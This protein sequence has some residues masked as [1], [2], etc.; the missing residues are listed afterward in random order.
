MF[1]QPAAGARARSETSFCFICFFGEGI[2][3]AR[4]EPAWHR[5][6]RRLRSEDRTLLRISAAA[7]RLH[8]HHGS[9][10]PRLTSQGAMPDKDLQHEKFDYVRQLEAKLKEI[11]ATN[12]KR[13]GNSANSRRGEDVRNGVYDWICEQCGEVNFSWRHFC[14][15]NRCMGRRPVEH[16]PGSVQAGDKSKGHGLGKGR[17]KTAKGS[18][19]KEGG[20]E[21]SRGKGRGQSEWI[22]VGKGMRK[23]GDKAD[24]GKDSRQPETNPR[25]STTIQ[26]RFSA[27]EDSSI[28]NDPMGS[29][30]EGKEDEKDEE[31]EEGAAETNETEARA[32]GNSKEATTN[33]TQVQNC[34]VDELWYKWKEE[35]GN[36]KSVKAALGGNRRHPAAEAAKSAMDRAR[37]AYLEARPEPKDRVKARILSNKTKRLQSRKD[38]LDKEIED[39]VTKT[40]VLEGKRDDVMRNLAATERDIAQL[41]EKMGKDNNQMQGR[42]IPE[43]VATETLQSIEAVIPILAKATQEIPQESPN[44]VAVQMVLAQL[45]RMEGVLAKKKPATSFKYGGS[46]GEWEKGGSDEE[47]W[48]EGEGEYDWNEENEDGNE[49][50]FGSSEENDEWADSL[51]PISNQDGQNQPPL[52][53]QVQPQQRSQQL[54]QHLQDEA[55]LGK[56]S[57]DEGDIAM[58]GGEAG[59]SGPAKRTAEIGTADGEKPRRARMG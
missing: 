1:G 46:D 8:K 40:K 59:S 44:R 10:I 32:E 56:G 12:H 49:D 43:E 36:W 24:G 27:I 47:E 52:H 41:R 37:A 35:E 29:D 53:S 6:E 22:G 15:R 19:G 23:P 4:K 38:A 18:G 14:F 13:G 30:D 17:G 11:E 54:Q 45:A 7:V 57:K 42:T 20:E 21:G 5:R 51:P 34:S 2:T 25:T 3:T 58:H 31:H 28:G 39:M 26:N 48:P 55:D 9:T 50:G 16:N 33:A